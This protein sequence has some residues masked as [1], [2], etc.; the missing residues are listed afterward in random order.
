MTLTTPEQAFLAV[1]VFL[2]AL[3]ERT[4]QPGELGLF[5]GMIAYVPGD[6]SL[7]PA[8]WTDWLAWVKK[9]QT[10]ELVPRNTGR[11]GSL[12]TEMMQPLNPEQAYLAMFAFI[13]EYWNVVSRPTEIGDLLGEMRYTPGVGTADPEMWKRWLA[14]IERVQ[15]SR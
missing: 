10:G 15:V 12:T 11:R 8:M 6:G 9:V 14:A 3:W 13:E 4:R 1:N 5:L 2:R 7:D